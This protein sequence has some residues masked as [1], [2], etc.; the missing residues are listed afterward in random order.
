MSEPIEYH[1]FRRGESCTYGGCPEKRYYIADGKRFC[2][3]G[4]EQEG[5]RQ[6]Q[7]DEDDFNTQGRVT[8][9]KREERERVERVFSGRDALELYL[10]C[11]MLVL[12]KQI[13]WLVKEKGL[14]LELETVVR[15]LFSVRLRDVR[16]LGKEGVGVGSAENVGFSSQSQADDVKVAKDS[17]TPKLI[18]SLGLCYL[19]I[20]SLRRGVTLGELH[21]WAAREEIV[22][23]RAVRPHSFRKFYGVEVCL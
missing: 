15:D 3:R 16:A 7:A 8:R 9:K 12:R 22:F 19:G 5:Y 4:H 2:K 17:R 23:L 21:R 1:K 14:P 11:Y 10:Q 13:W 18:D 6:I 20:L